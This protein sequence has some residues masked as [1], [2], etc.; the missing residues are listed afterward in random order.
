MILLF[1]VSG[2]I[3]QTDDEITLQSSLLKGRAHLRYASKHNIH[4]Q[5]Y[6][7]GTSIFGIIDDQCDPALHPFYVAYLIV[8]DDHSCWVY[9]S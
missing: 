8:H 1:Q 3:F 6:T 4:S 2:R 5:L 9:L 7:I